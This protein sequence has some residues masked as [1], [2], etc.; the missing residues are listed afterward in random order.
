MNNFTH[1]E[2]N[3]SSWQSG[4]DDGF[5]A[6]DFKLLLRLLCRGNFAPPVKKPR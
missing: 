6:S 4:R 5:V 3:F 1:D 2:S